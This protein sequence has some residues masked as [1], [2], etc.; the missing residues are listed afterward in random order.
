MMNRH[1]RAVLW[2][3]VDNQL[4]QL[5]SCA[6]CMGVLVALPLFAWAMAR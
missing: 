3:F 6:V 4:I 2:R 5:Y 1:I